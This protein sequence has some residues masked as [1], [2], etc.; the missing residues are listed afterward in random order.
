MTHGNTKGLWVQE[1]T[2]AEVNAQISKLEQNIKACQEKVKWYKDELERRKLQVPLGVPSD[3]KFY[4]DWKGRADEDCFDTMEDTAYNS[5]S[6]YESAKVHAKMLE[7]WRRDGLLANSKNEQITID[8]LRPLLKKG[9]VLYSPTDKKWKWV[10]NKTTICPE[11]YG[12]FLQGGKVV[13]IEGF[14]LKPAEDWE[15]SVMDC[16]L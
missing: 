15:K 2:E 13:P 3:G 4:V 6:S 7:E 11:N 5:F 9:K 12:W 16:G 1:I 8:V 14:N 10:D